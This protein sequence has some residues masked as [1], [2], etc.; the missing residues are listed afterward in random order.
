[1]AGLEAY[2]KMLVVI[3]DKIANGIKQE[4]LWTK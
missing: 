3:R 1:M 4:K 2:L